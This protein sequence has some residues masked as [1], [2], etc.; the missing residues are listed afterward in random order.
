MVLGNPKH[1]L[2]IVF[3]LPSLSKSPVKSV[4]FQ[5]Y[6]NK[7]FDDQ[8]NFFF[9][10]KNFGTCTLS[11]VTKNEFLWQS[12]HW[13][14]LQTTICHARKFAKNLE[15]RDILQRAPSYMKASAKKGFLLDRLRVLGVA[16]GMRENWVGDVL[17]EL[18]PG[19][20]R[21]FQK[22][23]ITLRV[24]LSDGKWENTLWS[25]PCVR[26]GTVELRSGP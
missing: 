25:G 24:I 14:C 26:S 22:S 1:D 5:K 16:K 7:I 21:F 9:Q 13:V 6:P 20:N 3:L 18:Y 10:T 4:H 2:L 8:K 19:S 23:G 17:E 11:E 15:N 12:N